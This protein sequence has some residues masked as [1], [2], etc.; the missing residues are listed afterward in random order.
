M[1][2][3]HAFG[4]ATASILFAA[5]SLPGY[6]QSSP[7][8]TAPSTTHSSS[9][10]TQAGT[11]LKHADKKFIEE[12]AQNGLAEVEL[13]KLAATKASSDDVKKFAQQM[14]DDHTKSNNELQQIAQNKGVTF[15]TAPD[16]SDQ[17]A[18]KKLEGLSGPEFDK[19]YLSE[20]GVK[21]HR[22]NQ[23]L[24]QNEAT[25]GQDPDLKT[26]AQKT[27]PVITHHLQMAQNMADSHNKAATK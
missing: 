24:F 11:E 2:V 22:D 19:R 15:P 26:F 13:G 18:L 3:S 10:G 14:V 25:K 9:T 23:K 8:S 4:L 5:Y 16:A 21:G 7:S 12:A 6:T 17:R 1:K 27:L 20:A